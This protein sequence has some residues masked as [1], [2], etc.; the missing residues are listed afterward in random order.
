MTNVERRG[1]PLSTS[2]K[3]EAAVIKELITLDRHATVSPVPESVSGN[4][5][6]TNTER[7]A[8]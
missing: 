8:I 2:V 4:P 3:S 7:I 1:H 5:L 6:A